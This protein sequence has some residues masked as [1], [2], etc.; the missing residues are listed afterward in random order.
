MAVLG[1]RRPRR[2][3]RATSS[4]AT[5]R[6]LRAYDV[7]GDHHTSGFICAG[8]ERVARGPVVP[9]GPVH[10]LRRLGPPAP[11]PPGGRLAGDR[12]A[13]GRCCCTLIGRPRTSHRVAGALPVRHDAIIRPTSRVL[14][15]PQLPPARP[16]RRPCAADPR[17][18]L[19]HAAALTWGPLKIALLGR[20]RRAKLPRRRSRRQGR[21]ARS[22][23]TPAHCVEPTGGRQD[24]P[25]TTPV[26]GV[27]RPHSPAGTEDAIGPSARWRRPRRRPRRRRV[28]AGHDESSRG[29]AP[30]GARW[31]RAG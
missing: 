23:R 24:K 17:W 20:D 1:P 31:T 14:P 9:V 30:R 28:Q 11:A 3:A 19:R 8:L 12:R 29:R 4:R 2:A 26:A 18:A 21:S 10:R 22:S 6:P 27:G 7:P 16:R 13:V 15:V 25:R 5:R